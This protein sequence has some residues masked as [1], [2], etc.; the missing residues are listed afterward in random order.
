MQL[1]WPAAG[2]NAE[3]TGKKFDDGIREGDIVF[4]V[5]LENVRRLHLLG[6]QKKSHVA[7]D[8]AGRR[9]FDDVAEELVDLGVHFFGFAPTMSEARGRGLLAQV[10]KLTAGNFMLIET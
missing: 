8:F 3:D 10:G 6:H 5:E 7:D 1:L 2:R 4:F 9:D